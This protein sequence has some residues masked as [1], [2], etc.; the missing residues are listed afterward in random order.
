MEK[1]TRL[2]IFLMGGWAI[3]KAPAIFSVIDCGR[4]AGSG[5]IFDGIP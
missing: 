5:R 3:E 1:E 4:K 2:G